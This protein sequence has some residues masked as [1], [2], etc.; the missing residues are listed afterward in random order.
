M[1]HARPLRMFF[2]WHMDIFN[3]PEPLRGPAAIAQGR[4]M[5][6]HAV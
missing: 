2:D 1:T 5:D 6:A 3:L 4:L